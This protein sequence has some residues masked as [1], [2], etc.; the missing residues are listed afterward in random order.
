MSLEENGYECPNTDK[1]SFPSRGKCRDDRP[2]LK[3]ATPSVIRKGLCMVRDKGNQKLYVIV[4]YPT[5]LGRKMQKNVNF[6]NNIYGLAF[7][8]TES[9][10]KY[11]AEVANAC[12]PVAAAIALGGKIGVG[13][14]LD[15]VDSPLR[16]SID[17]AFQKS[18]TR[19]NTTSTIHTLRPCKSC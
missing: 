12:D 9:A 6:T 2:I 4:F 17:S 15:H 19:R 10:I 16:C 5:N 18:P 11:G 13:N 7:K 1:D 8:A 3:C 14:S